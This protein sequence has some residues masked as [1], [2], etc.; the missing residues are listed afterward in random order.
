MKRQLSLL[1]GVALSGLTAHAATLGSPVKATLTIESSG[2]CVDISKPGAHGD[3]VVQEPCNKSANQIFTFTPV[4]AQGSSQFFTIT[5]VVGGSPLCIQESDNG[6]NEFVSQQLCT[7][8]GQNGLN[9]KWLGSQEADGSYKIFTHDSAQCLNLYTS[10]PKQGTQFVTAPCGTG[11]QQHFKS[12]VPLPIKIPGAVASPSPSPTV[13]P[14]P[15]PTVKP[16]PTP[17]PTVTTKPSP[18]PTVKP[19]PT[20]SPTVT[21]KPSPSPTPSATATSGT[22]TTWYIR[23]DGGTNTQCTGKTNAAYPGSGTTQAC[24]FNHP[25]QM[26]NSSGGWAAM[27]GGDTIQFADPSNVSHTYFIGEEN[28]GVGT[29]WHNNQLSNICPTAN[30]A[31]GAGA[32]CVLPIL[33]SGTKASPTRVIGQNAGSC[34]TAGHTGLVNPTI[35]S[36]ING[37]GYVL[38]VQATNYVSLSCIEVTQPDTCTANYNFGISGH[39][40]SSS[41]FVNGAGLMLGYL[42]NKGPSNF[43]LQDF[44]AVGIAVTGIQGSHINTA[45]T[46]VFNASDVYVIGNGLSGW[47]GDGG[48]CT[49]NCETV[50]TMNLSYVDVEWNGCVAVKPYVSTVGGNGF[51]YCHGQEDGGYGDGFVQVAAGNMTLNVTHGI[52]KYNTQDGFDSLHLSDDPKTSPSINISDSWSEGNGGQTFKLG[53]G[54]ASTAIN[55]VSISNCR[56]LSDSTAFAAYNNPKGWVALDSADTCRAGGDEWAFQLN[57]GT[58]VTLEN[59]TSVGYGTTMYDVECSIADPNC[60]ANGAKFIFKNNISMGFPDAGDS[61]QLASGIYLGA[62]D[63][64]ANAG[65]AINNNLWYNMNTGCPDNG[66]P[67]EKTAICADPRLTSESNI[68]AIVP[69]LTSSSPAIG[70]G[71]SL[72]NVTTDFNGT[73]R[74]NPP[75]VGAYQ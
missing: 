63:V 44:S 12:S 17:S 53:A 37:V 7:A 57:N 55:N 18:S 25:F 64:F 1:L 35:L 34:H 43:T 2:M 3:Y 74:P 31:A 16:S 4:A 71:V 40:A 15:S 20:P 26:L 27:K 38:S 70:A 42:G 29:D 24:A 50:G 23:Q 62:G 59:N 14:S 13:K 73:A 5:T 58:T 41:N 47:D 68:N 46:D 6:Q 49:T 66:I 60:A 9:Q 36:G 28:N 48:G 69:T 65:S 33:P 21:T 52:F 22:G 54:T 11:V 45:S 10:N 61:N 19:S 72:S 75:A 51:N 30:S 8:V 32:D 67:E 56:I 39:C